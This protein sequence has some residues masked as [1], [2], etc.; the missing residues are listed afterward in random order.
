MPVEFVLG[1][2]NARRFGILRT[3]YFLFRRAIGSIQMEFLIKRLNSLEYFCM[4]TTAPE[5]ARLAASNFG[6][7]DA[8][9][10]N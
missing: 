2:F 10:V 1:S 8:G 7:W 6:M 4:A 9:G 5:S 3:D